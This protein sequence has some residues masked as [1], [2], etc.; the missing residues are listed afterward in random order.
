M[1]EDTW[2]KSARVRA[3]LPSPQG[4]GEPLLHLEQELGLGRLSFLMSMLASCPGR[5][6]LREI[7]GGNHRIRVRWGAGGVR[8]TDGLTWCGNGWSVEA[9]MASGLWLVCAWPEEPHR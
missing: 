6:G 1:L 2:G 3:V 9:G 5:A 4:R 7:R 8:E